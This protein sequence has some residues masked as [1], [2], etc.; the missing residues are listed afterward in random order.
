MKKL[1]F[2]FLICTAAWINGYS[3]TKE[4][5][6]KEL[7]KV[8]KQDSL[9]DKTFS[10]IIPSMFNQMQSQMK[11][12]TAKA[13]SQEA[14]KS[15]MSV[16]KDNLKR[17]INEDMVAIY[18]KNFTKHEIKDFIKFYKSTSGQ[19]LV[20]TQPELQKEMMTVFLQKY[21]PEIQK[22]TKAKMEEMKAKENK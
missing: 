6:I 22:A 12:S 5:L 4:E 10:S 7:F 16:M 14:M 3:Q 15:S 21:L 13:R 20:N 8:M 1:A 19:K 18:D 17:M 9:I 11:D 2:V